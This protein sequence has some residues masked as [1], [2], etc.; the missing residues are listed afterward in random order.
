M[1]EYDTM[2]FV[3]RSLV[4]QEDAV[5]LLEYLRSS[6]KTVHD[7]PI[8]QNLG[9]LFFY[10]LQTDEEGLKL[11]MNLFQENLLKRKY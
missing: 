7:Y 5:P 10:S 6:V 11:G 8:G 1:V 2:F 9:Q 4:V 3:T